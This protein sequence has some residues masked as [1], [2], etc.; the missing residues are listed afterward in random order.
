MTPLPC[1]SRSKSDRTGV[2]LVGDLGPPSGRS[3]RP[4]WVVSGSCVIGLA[5]LENQ[6]VI[7]SLIPMTDNGVRFRINTPPFEHFRGTLA[8][9]RHLP[10]LRVDNNRVCIKA[11]PNNIIPIGWM[12]TEYETFIFKRHISPKSIPPSEQRLHFKNSIFIFGTTNETNYRL[13][14]PSYPSI[15]RECQH[16]RA[17]QI[18]IRVRLR[19]R[20]FSGRS[21]NQKR[22]CDHHQH[23][24]ADLPSGGHPHHLMEAAKLVPILIFRTMMGQYPQRVDSHRWGPGRNSPFAAPWPG[25]L[26]RRVSGG[27]LTSAPGA[28]QTH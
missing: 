3:E 5:G 9:R 22:S 16:T 26:E 13:K 11:M 14:T 12:V 10:G 4:R 1:Q 23:V 2:R 20:N 28:F 8:P 15:I 19:C 24:H 6:T 18:A 25:R 17:F 21:A 27:A 7:I